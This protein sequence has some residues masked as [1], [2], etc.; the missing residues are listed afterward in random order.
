M[1]LVGAYVLDRREHAGSLEVVLKYPGGRE[2]RRP[3]E[4]IR[5][6]EDVIR[7]AALKQW[8]QPTKLRHSPGRAPEAPT[9]HMRQT[10]AH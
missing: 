3:V 9:P 4:S 7:Q 2:I 1:E 6:G 5:E 10:L 8:D